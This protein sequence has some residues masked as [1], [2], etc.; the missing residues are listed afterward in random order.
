MSVTATQLRKDLYQT[1]DRA[2]QGESVEI[3][4][5]G[6]TILLQPAAGSKLSRAVRRPTLLVNPDAIVESDGD[7]MAELEQKWQREAES[8]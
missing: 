3:S 1:L 8:L 6:A 5:K 4:Y 2:I 7:L